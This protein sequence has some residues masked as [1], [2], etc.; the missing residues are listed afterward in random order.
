[1]PQI[2][3]LLE[4][5]HLFCCVMNIN[6]NIFFIFFF[7]FFFFF[8]ILPTVQSF[9]FSISHGV[10]ILVFAVE[11]KF[12]TFAEVCV[13]ADCVPSVFHRLP[14]IRLRW[15]R[16]RMSHFLSS[17]PMCRLI[18]CEPS[19]CRLACIEASAG[20]LPT[21]IRP[22]AEGGHDRHSAGPA[23]GHVCGEAQR[24]EGGG[25]R[26]PQG[27]VTSTDYCSIYLYLPHLWMTARSQLH[28]FVY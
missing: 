3:V 5:I 8:L 1:M 27:T 23:V 15:E 7:F 14:A 24:H 18:M 28:C 2:S 19:F 10:I 20:R 17:D 26:C 21:A 22:A 9:S 12:A 13:A 6:W 25:Y 11:V 16:F 4:L